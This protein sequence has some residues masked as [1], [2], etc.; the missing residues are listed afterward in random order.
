M[1]GKI[2]FGIHVDKFFVVN[3]LNSSFTCY[4]V[5]SPG[6]IQYNKNYCKKKMRHKR[7]I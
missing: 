3:F 2:A 7:D 6:N 1:K 4:G 5:K